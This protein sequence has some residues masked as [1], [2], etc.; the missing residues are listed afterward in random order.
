MTLLTSQT[1]PRQVQADAIVI[2]VVQGPDG[3]LPAP[4]AQDVDQAL[5]GSLAATLSVLGATGRAEEVTKIA[6]A[7]RLA[8]PLIVA[9]G[10]GK[11]AVDA[12]RPKRARA[13]KSATTPSKKELQKAKE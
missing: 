13:A 7:G 6:T 5:D 8:A 9:V 4:G 2:G 10:I 11:D 12:P 3:P 1:S